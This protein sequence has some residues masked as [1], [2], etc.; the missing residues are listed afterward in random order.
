MNA[1]RKRQQE[2]HR[3]EMLEERNY[4]LF[5]F[6]LRLIKQFGGEVINAMPDYKE[7]LYS[8]KPLEAKYWVDVDKLANLN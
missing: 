6:Q 7:I 4:Q 2:I 3:I 1:E 5:Y 8:D